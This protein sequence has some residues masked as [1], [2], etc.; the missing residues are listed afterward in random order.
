MTTFTK[1]IDLT[2]D[3]QRH[4]LTSYTHRF[5]KEHRP[6]WATKEWKDGKPYPVQFEDDQDWLANTSFATRKNGRLDHRFSEC[7]SMPTWPDNPE[8]R[9]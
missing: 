6:K 9:N 2:P 8:L 3:D 5:T 4:V 7:H 1:G